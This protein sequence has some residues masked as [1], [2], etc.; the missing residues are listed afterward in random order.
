MNCAC[1]AGTCLSSAEGSGGA[2][3]AGGES[4]VQLTDCRFANNSAQARSLCAVPSP[5]EALCGT[6]RRMSLA[7]VSLAAFAADLLMTV[8]MSPSFALLVRVVTEGRS[9]PSGTSSPHEAHSR[10]AQRLT[11]EARVVVAAR[12]LVAIPAA[13]SAA[14]DDRPGAF[15]C[16][17]ASLLEM[18]ECV[19]LTGS[20]P[21]R[22]G[23]GAVFLG[24]SGTRAGVKVAATGPVRLAVQGSSFVG[25]IAG[26]TGGAVGCFR[27]SQRIVDSLLQANTADDGG[28]VHTNSP[29]TFIGTRLIDNVASHT[30]GAVYTTSMLTLSPGT[31]ILDNSALSGNGGAAACV[32]GDA[33]LSADGILVSGN[34]AYAVGGGFFLNSDTISVTNS[35]FSSNTAEGPFASSG[36]IAAVS[37]ATSGELLMENVTFERNV[38]RQRELGFTSPEQVRGIR[39]Q[40]RAQI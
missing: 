37:F 13:S 15:D 39:V 30:G 31:V 24:Q 7:R 36:A 29:A 11:L 20:T 25:N 27:A 10:T 1:R 3:W 6:L 38:V 4:V 9:T 2:L 18:V 14:T 26:N 16:C 21:L 22:I 5:E 17:P 28:A 34:R 35:V 40:P 23:A 19:A 33:L 12:S 8:L 32:S